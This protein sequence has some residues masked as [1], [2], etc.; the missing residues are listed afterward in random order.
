MVAGLPQARIAVIRRTETSRVLYLGG[1][2][3]GADGGRRSQS[4]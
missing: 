1:R 2:Q 4:L 3:V